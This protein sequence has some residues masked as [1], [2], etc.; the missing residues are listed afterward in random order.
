MRASNVLQTIMLP[1]ALLLAASCMATFPPP[2]DARQEDRRAPAGEQPAEGA[3]L[4]EGVA[5]DGP[6]AGALGLEE[7]ERL[8]LVERARS[9][10]G[11]R[12]LRLADP[13]YRRNDC[14]GFVVGVYRSLGWKV[15]LRS[16]GGASR[17][18]ELLFKNLHASRLT[19]YN[20]SPRIGDLVFFTGTI[21]GNPGRITHVGMISALEEDGTV[22]IIHYS[23]LGVTAIRMNLDHPGR[24]ALDDGRVIN[25]YVRKRPDGYA[26][27]PL[28]AGELFH[29]YGDLYTFAKL[30]G[31]R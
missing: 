19:F 17:I 28:L 21:P 30:N 29:A 23:S 2:R 9:M 14:T 22:E 20:A 3:D 18:S 26:N 5:G 31:V 6:S 1:A 25:D 11:V 4:P 10:V 7:G 12:D 27:V 8:A 15:P 24:H 16:Y 13:V